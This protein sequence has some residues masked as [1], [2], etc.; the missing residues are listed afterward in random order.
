MSEDAALGEI[1]RR[2]IARRAEITEEW[3]HR[4]AALPE[5]ARLPPSAIVDHMPEFLYELAYAS[6]GSSEAARRAYERLIGGHTLQRLGFGVELATLLE[7]YAV[8]RQVILAHLLRAGP[9]E[10]HQ[11]DLLQLDRTL[12]LAIIG[13]VRTFAARRDE[14]RDQFVGM[15]A[16]DLRSPL[17]AL[18]IGAETILRQA[19][20][21]VPG[22][23]RAAA[24]IRRSADRMRRLISD[25]IDFARGQRGGGIPAVPVTCDMGEICREVVD[26]VRVAHPARALTIVA[27]GDL[28]GSWDRDRLLQ[29][30]SNLVSNALIHG[31]DP[32]EIRAFEEPDRQ[33]VTTEIHNA[34]P[35]IPDDVMPTLFDPFRRGKAAKPG[36]LGLG[37]FIIQQIAL[38]HGAECRVRS[39]AGEGTT[40][41]IQWPRAPLSEVPR[42]YQPAGG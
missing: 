29:A 34:G 14:L 28:I 24:A 2:L 20:C 5:L 21:G 41:W 35:P 27:S 33:S 39:S 11:D 8:L 17:Q 3:R 31:S 4:A 9:A 32:V 7:E 37:L 12:D 26:E 16:H 22:H 23:E 13:S 25:V 1:G 38:A 6:A 18:I 42:P 30:L 15:L 19:D 36:G 40:F 10:L